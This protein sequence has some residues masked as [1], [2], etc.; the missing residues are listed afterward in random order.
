MHWNGILLIKPNVHV[1]SN[2][3]C[4]LVY[5]N[6]G[7]QLIGKELKTAEIKSNQ[8]QRPIAKTKNFCAQT[9]AYELFC[10]TS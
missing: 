7:F 9:P 10:Q 1:L 2:P 3:C 8:L 4:I 5:S 6:E